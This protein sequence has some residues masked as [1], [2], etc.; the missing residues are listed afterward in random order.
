MNQYLEFAK[1]LEAC[2]PQEKILID[3][4]MKNH[5]NFKLGGPADIMVL[6]SSQSELE[7]ILSQARQ[8]DIPCFIIGNGSNLVVRDGGIRGLVIKL[9]QLNQI[10]VEGDCII[11]D[12]GA[13]LKKLSDLAL[14]HHLSGL[15]FACGIPGTLGGAVFMNAGAYDGEMSHVLE[16]VTI[17]TPQGEKQVL[18]RD[19][20]ELGYRTS[21]VKTCGDIVIQ[22]RMKLT[23]GSYDS[24]QARIADLTKKREDKQP[25]EYPSAGSTFKRPV[26]HYAGKLIQ[27]AGLKGYEH[28]GAAVSDKHSGF[29]INKNNATAQ[30]VLELIAFVQKTVRDL[31][32]IQLDPE[33][34][35]VGEDL[36]QN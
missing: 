14:T 4:P 19:E 21:R 34:L 12:S 18:T 29:I 35:I 17:V 36:K 13:E 26:G 9:E 10:R 28:N 31:Y 24:I 15:E 22:A 2:L 7:C 3:E 30:D 11:A 8:E 25:L 16:S 20:L 1:R 32:E 5:T 27:D 33:V 6:P 23:P